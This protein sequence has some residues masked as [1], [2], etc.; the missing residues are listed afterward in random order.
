MDKNFIVIKKIIYN[1]ILYFCRD[2]EEMK[3][4]E[5]FKIFNGIDK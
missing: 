3:K 1:E 2:V 4:I 5:K